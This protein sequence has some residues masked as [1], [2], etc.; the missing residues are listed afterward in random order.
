MLQR[1]KLK[2]TVIRLFTKITSA[3]FIVH[4][5]RKI[6]ITNDNIKTKIMNYLEIILLRR[7]NL[8]RYYQFVNI[9][10]SCSSEKIELYLNK[11]IKKY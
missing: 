11:S 5:H 9:H 4:I 7:L 2:L 3:T 10:P 8:V 1:R 6:M